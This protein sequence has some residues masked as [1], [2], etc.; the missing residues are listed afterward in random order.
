MNEAIDQ[1]MAQKGK[2]RIFSLTS[3][4]GEGRTDNPKEA[5]SDIDK[6]LASGIDLRPSV[7]NNFKHFKKV[8]AKANKEVFIAE[9]KSIEL[10][11][12][13]DDGKAHPMD[14]R[15]LYEPYIEETPW[16]TSTQDEID[17]LGYDPDKEYWKASRAAK[18]K[19][20]FGLHEAN[21]KWLGPITH[22]FGLT[23]MQ[24]AV[25]KHNEKHMVRLYSLTALFETG[26]TD[27]PTEAHK[28]IGRLLAHG[29]GL[30]KVTV[31]N[32]RRL[33][34]L[35]AKAKEQV[36]LEVYRGASR[37]APGTHR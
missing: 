18:A 31:A 35:L 24:R 17:R 6:L 26:R 33:N 16:E 37:K 29:K 4:F 23:L 21:H 22:S 19:R 8:L 5:I 25:N 7:V 14:L 30:S 9:Y 27:N 15:E 12:S 20:A 10:V 11:Y 2:V 13:G 36:V 32:F 28:D 3:L 1:C 34:K